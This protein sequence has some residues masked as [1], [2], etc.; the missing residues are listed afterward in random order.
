LSSP[1]LPPPSP[2]FTFFSFLLF[3]GAHALGRC[4]V[5]R[6]GF[7]GPWTFSPISFTNEYYR[8][9]FFSS[10]SPISKLNLVRFAGLL[11]DEKWSERKW[12]GPPQFENKSDK[13]LMM[14][15]TDMALTTDKVRLSLS[16]YSQTQVTDLFPIVRLSDPGRRSTLRTRRRSSTT[17]ARLSRRSSPSLD[18]PFCSSTSTDTA[19][20]SLIHLGVPE[21]QLSEPVKLVKTEDQQPATA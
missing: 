19:S 1:S 5:D 9:S 10:S 15:R 11:F 16:P 4:H 3:A 20:H 21:S 17:S 8:S 2:F 13:S 6:S 18:S 12:N 14:L 7:D